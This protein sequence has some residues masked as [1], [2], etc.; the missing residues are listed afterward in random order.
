M[1]ADLR[2]MGITGKEMQYRCDENHMTLN[3]NAIPGDP[4]KPSVTSG[5]RLG[6]P[7]VTT[8]GLGESEMKE[9][10]RCIA[11]TARDYENSKTQVHDVVREICEKYPLY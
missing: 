5:V 8:R 3:K 1:L 9:I 11:L 2:P 7:A 10:G 6:T 4:E